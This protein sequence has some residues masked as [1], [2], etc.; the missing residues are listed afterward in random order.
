[1]AKETLFTGVI[2]TITVAIVFFGTFIPRIYF[3][4]DVEAAYILGLL[5]SFYP[6]IGVIVVELRNKRIKNSEDKS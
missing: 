3:P 1:M 2:F 6:I 5:M 4:H